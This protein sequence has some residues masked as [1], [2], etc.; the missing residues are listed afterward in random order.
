M[1]PVENLI[2]Y[3]QMPVMKPE[4]AVLT[5][6]A[7]SSRSPIRSADIGFFAAFESP[8]TLP[9]PVVWTMHFGSRTNHV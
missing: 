8:K 1:Q 6:G 3:W 2:N 5:T 9:L 7:N 4:S